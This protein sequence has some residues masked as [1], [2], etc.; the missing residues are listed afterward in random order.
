MC[1][2]KPSPEMVALQKE[3]EVLRSLLISLYCS[4]QEQDPVAIG[5]AMDDI[6]A[7]LHQETLPTPK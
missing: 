4:R 6:D 7:F 2:P 5:K 3:N 1:K